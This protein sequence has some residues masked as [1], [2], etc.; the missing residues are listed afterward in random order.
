MSNLNASGELTRYFEQRGIAE[1][2]VREARIG[3]EAGAFTYPCLSKE[4]ILLGVHGKSKSRNADNKRRQ[5]WGRYAED[6]PQKGHG[7]KP[8][9]PAKV[10]PFGLETL[11][12]VEPDSQVVL[13]CGEEGRFKPSSM[14]S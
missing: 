3:Y 4:G 14:W 1:K 5:W 7:E 13:T 9:D 12:D 10:I 8:E 6:L 2:T 11:K